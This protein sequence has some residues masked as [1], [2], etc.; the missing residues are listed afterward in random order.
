MRLHLD[1]LSAALCFGSIH[2]PGSYALGFVLIR[3][4]SFAPPVFLVAFPLFLGTPQPGAPQSSKTIVCTKGEDIVWGMRCW[5]WHQSQIHFLRASKL[6]RK[7]YEMQFVEKQDISV[8]THEISAK[9][10]M[11][12]GLR[13]VIFMQK[14]P[15]FLYL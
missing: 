3:D 1:F 6:S 5:H 7:N 4:L 9:D 15:L 12:S 10:S 11:G 14:Q 13:C 2:Q 8:V